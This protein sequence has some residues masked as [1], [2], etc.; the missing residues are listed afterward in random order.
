[1][2]HR[3]SGSDNKCHEMVADDVQYHSGRVSVNPN[4]TC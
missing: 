1:M 2:L 3:F 4:P